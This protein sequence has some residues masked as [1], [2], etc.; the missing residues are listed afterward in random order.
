[1]VGAGCNKSKYRKNLPCFS[2]VS[3]KIF[4]SAADHFCGAFLWPGRFDDS[5][6]LVDIVGAFAFS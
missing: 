1:M 5:A 3:K 4:F 2:T 6:T